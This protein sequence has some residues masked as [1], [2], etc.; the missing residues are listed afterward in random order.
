[1]HTEINDL[2]L[3]SQTLRGQRHAYAMLVNRYRD[4]VYTLALR[5]VNNREDAEEVAQDAFLKA[6]QA[7]GQFRG[8]SKFS[9]WL[10]TIVFNTACTLQRKKQLEVN[11]IENKT[12]ERV[13]QNHPSHWNAD[14]VLHNND[15]NR[16]LEYAINKLP[17][18]YAA[19]ITLFY[20]GENSIE[21]IAA[22]TN[23]EIS[24]VKVRLHRARKMLKEIL[25]IRLQHEL[26]DVLDN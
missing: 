20:Q 25:E 17:Q 11:S 2:E 6:Y 23:I 9:T 3:I 13:L 14:S 8:Q 4:F 18:E 16:E 10:Y 24:N 7:L 26:H 21:E 19:V 15:R 12:V 5:V 22:I 1:M